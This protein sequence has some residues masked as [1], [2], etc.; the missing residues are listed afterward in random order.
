[1]LGTGKVQGSREIERDNALKQ[2]THA[3]IKKVTEDMEGTFHFNTAISSIMELVNETYDYI[4]LEPTALSLEFKEAIQTI[5]ILLSPFV[6]HI[7][8]EMW[9]RLG[10]KESIFRAKWPDYDKNALNQNTIELPIQ[11]NGKLRSKI[12]APFNAEEDEIKKLVLEDS[13]I[14]KWIEGKPLKKIIIV[15]GKLVNLVI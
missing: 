5:I 15:K 11:I 6:P 9:E 7:A 13:V 3:T 4:N 10:N 8:E 1:L 12:E 14:N 2:K